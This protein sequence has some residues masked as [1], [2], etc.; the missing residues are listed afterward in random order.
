MFKIEFPIPLKNLLEDSDLQSPIRAYADRIGEVLTDNKLPFFPDYT[1][2]GISHINCVLKSEVELIPKHVWDQ[3]KKDSYPRLLCDADAVVIIGATLLHD[4]AMHL[5]PDGFRELISNDSRFQP[6]PWF[7][8][9][10][11]D[12]AADRP[13]HEL[14]DEYAREARRFND[15]KLS[16]IV[17][18]ESVRRGWKFHKLPEDA[19]QWEHNHFLIIGEFIRRHHARL[20]HEIAI[21]GFPGLPVGSGE[22]R[23]S[24]MGREPGHTLMRLA[25]LIGLAAR[26]HGITLRV[27]KAYIESSPLYPGTPRPMGAAI[28]YPMALLRVADYLQIDRQRAPAVLLQ[29]RNPQSPVSVQ[30]WN[31]HLAVHSIGP[32]NDPRG[33]MVIVSTSVSLELYLQLKDLLAGLQKEMDHATAVLDETYGA[34]SDLGLNQLNLAIRRVYSNLHSL[35]F[36][37]S[38][39]YVPE[40]TGFSSDPNLLTLL[41]EPLYGKQP[42]VGVRELMQNAVDA[43]RE[44]DAWC[45]THSKEDSSLDLPKQ[46]ADVLIDFI[47]R[48]DGSW[49]MRMRDRGIGMTGDTLQNFFLRAGASFRQSADWAKEFLDD[50][51]QPRVLRAGRF[52]VGAFAAFLLG[53]T[54]K[55]QT[56][57]A[58]A[59]PSMAYMLEASKDSQLIEI[60]RVESLQVGTTIE[61]D[62]TSESVAALELDHEKYNE[63]HGPQRSTDWFCWDWPKVVRRVV[64]SP[65]PEILAQKYA[66]AFHQGKPGLEWSVIRPPKFDA[67]YWTFT[68]APD[69][70]CNGLKIFDGQRGGKK[71]GWPDEA[72]LKS[73]N[74]A[75]FDSAANLPLTTQRHELSQD[76]VPFISELVRDVTFSFIAHALICG[77]SSRIE[78]LSTHALHPLSPEQIPDISH[79]QTQPLS[80]G[81]LRWCVTPNGGVPVDPWLYSLLGATSCLVYG[82]IARDQWRA[83]PY[84]PSLDQ[85]SLASTAKVDRA[86]L[87]W[88]LSSNKSYYDDADDFLRKTAE[89]SNNL[90]E[91]LVRHGIDALGHQVIASN[92]VVLA[93]QELDFEACQEEFRMFHDNEEDIP[94]DWQKT[95]NSRASWQ[96][97]EMQHG[98]LTSNMA[99]EPLIEM[100]EDAAAND[101]SESDLP[102]VLFVAEIQTTPASRF[103]ETLFAKI[104]NECLGPQIIPFDP[105]ARKTLIEQGRQHP[106]LKLHIEKW[107]KMKQS[108]SKW[109]NFVG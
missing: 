69:L 88:H 26:S 96:R 2:H 60:S 30:E 57:H 18:Q 19:G 17:G 64:C 87:Y 8:E 13:W 41:V 74:L 63:Y 4:I 104:W 71:I 9:D 25:D 95:S 16:D 83:N 65:N 46:D 66:A 100:I 98:C 106:E 82:A 84:I 91:E 62:L 39:P 56:R 23:F 20:A 61:V 102:D 1:D 24:A 73:P 103:P 29:L 59:P 54:F 85:A 22:G 93:N 72:Q 35:A 51:G 37:D 86:M 28:L 101:S 43:V 14:W 80:T 97:F 31:K 44:L 21:Y 15:R 75:V 11:E 53:P 48:E 27:C 78:A 67:V 7:K 70:A 32:A 58:S 38:L 36:R 12:H 77:P 108:N 3:S 49:F 105:D 79:A 5:R 68:D 42:E 34:R 92:I 50:N 76:A 45:N 6:L 40:R 107:E 99:L 55:L 47:K 81:C 33:K 94:V 89:S 109:T 10:Q 52:G 90:L